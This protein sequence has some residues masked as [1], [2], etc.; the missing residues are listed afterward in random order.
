MLNRRQGSPNQAARGY[1]PQ[2]PEK[3]IV[4]RL[5]IVKHRVLFVCED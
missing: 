2:L 4:L 3:L 1:N 5:G